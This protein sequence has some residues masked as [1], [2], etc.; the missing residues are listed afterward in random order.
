MPWPLASDFRAIL[1]T[2]RVAFR[3]PLLRSCTVERDAL[4]QP[5]AWA[6]AFAV[7][8]KGIDETGKPLAIRVFST[9]SPHRR[10][11]YSHVGQ[12]LA[13]RRPPCLVPFEYREDEI[14]S[15]DGKRYPVVLMDWVEGETLSQWLNAQC[16]SGN[17][18]AISGAAQQWPPL[19]EELSRQQIAHGDLQHGNI[20]VTVDGELKL[21]DYDGMCVPALEG[22]EC[23]E[24]GTPP[25]QH[26]QRSGALRL[27]PRLDDFSAI[28]IHVAL[29]A[30]SAD[31]TLWTRYVVRG[32]NE[33]ILFRADDFR[34][35][36]KSALRG[37]LRHSAAP[38]VRDISERLFAA[39]AGS[40]DRVPRLCELIGPLQVSVQDAVTTPYPPAP[41]PQQAW[42]SR[43]PGEV[44]TARTGSRPTTVTPAAVM[45]H[46]GGY[47]MISE[48]GKGPL[49]TVFLAESETTRQM[50][51]VKIM[52]IKVPAT[53][54]ARRKFLMDMDRAGQIRHPNIAAL[55]GRGTVGH[56]FYCIRE[57]CPRGNLAQWMERQGGKLETAAV[58]VVM[59]QCLDALKQAHLHRLIHGRI[60]PQNILF[61]GS[62][63]SPVAKLSDLAVAWQFAEK[64]A[65]QSGI[66]A[67]PGSEGFVPPEQLTGRS[68]PT[69]RSDLWSLAAVFYYALAGS[70]PWEFSG[71]NPRDVILAA[72]PI[73]L[74]QRIG[75][76]PPSVA[77]V[78]DRALRP[79]PVHRFQ[80][81]AEMKAAWDA[82]F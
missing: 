23:L 8:Y 29:Q 71:R 38:Q 59:Q 67:A 6:G 76:V 57:Y 24:V 33:A 27:S 66:A 25:Y 2:P 15:F 11:R 26:P 61:A 44:V 79:N 56:S 13:D 64:F 69:S 20:M 78:I 35:P 82:A 47:K 9:E 73:P 1:Q 32:N 3:D 53:D 39:A 43:P 41:A 36:Q 74:G 58:R 42:P 5:R 34:A 72:D 77:S 19:V 81:V 21:V 14:R 51:A 49:S 18:T 68:G 46:I 22:A 7:V 62:D 70:Y 16:Q 17:V 80:S 50:C 30:L 65:M 60:T 10:E 28:L 4:G 45:P 37:D 52:P 12:Y 40:I 63:E 48:L 75:G 31:P 55:L 54:L